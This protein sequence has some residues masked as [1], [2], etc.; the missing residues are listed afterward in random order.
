MFRT[1]RGRLVLSYLLV[2]LVAALG[3]GLVTYLIASRIFGARRSN[4]SPVTLPRSPSALARLWRAGRT[5]RF[6]PS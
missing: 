3:V 6:Y 2:G 1:V 4:M 5:G